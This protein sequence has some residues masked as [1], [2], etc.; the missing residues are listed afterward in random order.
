[1]LRIPVPESYE[2]SW[3]PASVSHSAPGCPEPKVC[4]RSVPVVGVNWGTASA[5]PANSVV[6][7]ATRAI[8]RAR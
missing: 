5:V 7:E 4:S 2:I 1:M 8:P 3:P 6:T